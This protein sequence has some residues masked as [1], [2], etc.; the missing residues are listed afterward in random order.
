MT[1]PTHLTYTA[2]H[3]WLLAEEGGTA[4]VGITQ[5]AADALGDVVFAELPEPG[6]VLTAGAPCGELESTKAVSEIYA[7]ADGEVVEVNQAVID[8][9]GVLNQDPYGEGWLFVLRVTGPLDLLDA[10]AYTDQ[11][12]A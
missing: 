11:I 6:V 12:G 10:A 9:P 2:E 4:R 1:V 8:D 7:P 3:E 5:H